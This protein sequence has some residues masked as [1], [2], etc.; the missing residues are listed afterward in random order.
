MQ[1]CGPKVENG[2]VGF[3]V[4]HQKV[5]EFR[6]VSV[7]LKKKNEQKKKKRNRTCLGRF[8]GETS[9]MVNISTGSVCMCWR[10]VK[11]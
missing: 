11:T 1:G 6:S 4:S 7:G 5:G 8:L 9:Q 10:N 3:S 2:S